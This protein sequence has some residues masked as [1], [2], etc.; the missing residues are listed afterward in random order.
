MRLKT[1]DAVVII[2]AVIG[3]LDDAGGFFNN[4]LPTNLRGKTIVLYFSNVNN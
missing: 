1:R 4:S 3:A 2:A